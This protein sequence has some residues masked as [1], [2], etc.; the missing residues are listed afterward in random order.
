MWI[1]PEQIPESLEMY[2]LIL[3][4]A[5]FI[6]Q[7]YEHLL[8]RYS[9]LAELSI[10]KDKG[11]DISIKEAWE[12]HAKRSLNNKIVVLIDFLR[13]KEDTSAELLIRLSPIGRFPCRFL[14]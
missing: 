11:Y 8:A 3:G 5:L 2:F 9:V 12:K 4:R 13:T 7:K 14:A 6:C 10:K 1:F